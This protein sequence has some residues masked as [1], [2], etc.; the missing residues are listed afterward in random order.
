M[1][2]RFEERFFGA[3]WHFLAHFGTFFPFM[4]VSGSIEN[5]EISMDNSALIQD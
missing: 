4:S 3:F 1:L 5:L 2:G